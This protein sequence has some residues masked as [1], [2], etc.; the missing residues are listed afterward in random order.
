MGFKRFSYRIG[1]RIAFLTLTIAAWAYLFTLPGYPTLHL[2]LT[3]TV[4]VQI[5]GIFRLVSRTNAELTRFLEALRYAD[6]GQR[7]D[8]PDAGTGFEE[9]GTV[10]T[11]I[12]DRFQTE[13]SHREED[14]R[15]LR[16][17]T[18]HVP[19]PLLSLHPDGKIKLHNNAARR[20][21]G[22]VSI[23]RPRDLFPFGEDF[24]K[25]VMAVEA[26]ERRL[27]TFHLDNLE[28]QFTISATEI[29]IADQMEKLVSL[30]NIQSELDGAQLQAWQD[31]VRVLTHEIMNSVTPVASLAKTAAE[32]V[33]DATLK[34]KDQPDIVEELADVKQAVE[35]MARRSDDLMEFVQSYRRI[36]RLPQPE[37]KRI[38]LSRLFS[39]VEQLVASEWEKKGIALSMSVEPLSLMVFADAAMVEQVL[40]NLLQNAEQVLAGSD[41]AKVEVHG[42]LNRQ[43]HA[44]IEV[45]D[46]GPGVPADIAK[47]VF[48]PFFTTKREG[49]GVG[50]AL[51][52]QVMLAHGGTVTLGANE[53]GGAKF[54]LTFLTNRA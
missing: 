9:L 52:R 21:F 13:R 51:T 12:I 23:T 19:L 22:S 50:L 54:T 39:N 8:M 44:C 49:S 25:Q 15:H 34:L 45:S 14:L 7:F 20:L 26:G 30:N 47:K 3:A 35:T 17:L 28:Q 33:A 31:L 5:V 16:A 2:L 11:E 6:F 29:V 42:C 1:F 36:T 38:L 53:Y 18:E 32:L 10:F 48:V 37:E 43:G 41:N 27:A 4:A 40:F 46:N 24:A